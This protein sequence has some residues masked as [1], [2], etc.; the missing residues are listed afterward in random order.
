MDKDFVL[1]QIE[2]IEKEIER[3]KYTDKEI[4]EHVI[5]R[6]KRIKDTLADD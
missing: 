4:I 6:F 1:L 5:A 3:G 2:I